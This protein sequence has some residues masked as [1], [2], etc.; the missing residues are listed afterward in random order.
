MQISLHAYLTQKPAAHQA[1][2]SRQAHCKSLVKMSLEIGVIRENA[3]DAADSL[4]D[5]GQW[6]QSE[7][8]DGLTIPGPMMS[9]FR[10]NP[11]ELTCARIA[12]KW[13]VL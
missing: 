4:V 8:F 5:P 3:S 11:F 6:L 12:C 10:E 7:I 13:F 2:G 1:A 9:C